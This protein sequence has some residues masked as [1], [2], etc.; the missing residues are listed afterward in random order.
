VRESERQLRLLFETM[1]QGVVYQDSQGRITSLNPAAE[2]I[3]GQTAAVLVGRDSFGSDPRTKREDDTLFPPGEQPSAVAFNSGTAVHAVTMGIYNPRKHQYRWVEVSAVPLIREG[4]ARPYQVYT[5]LNDVTE[6]KQAAEALRES[7]ARLRLAVE[8]T[9]VGTFDFYPKTGALLW[10]DITKSHFGLSPQAAIDHEIFLSAVHPDDRERIRRKGLEVTSPGSDGNL[11]TEYRTIGVED[12]KER[13]LSVRGRVLYDSEGR[14]ERLIGTTLDI[15]ER[16]SLEEQ[17]RRRAEECQKIM[18]VAPVVLHVAHDRDCEMVTGNRAGYDLHET[19]EGSNLSANPGLAAVGTRF[20]RNG[21]ELRPEQLPLQIAAARGEEV[22]D[23]EVELLLPSGKKVV[24]WGHATPLRDATGQVRGAVGAFQ[25][26][27]RSKRRNEAALRESE[28]RFR[29]MADAAPIVMW[30]GDGQKRVTFFNKEISAF[31]GLPREQLLGVG[32]AQIIHPDDLEAAR[33]GYYDAVDRRTSNQ[34]EYRAR[35]A[36]GEYR[37]MLGTTS[38]RYIEDEY[39]GQVGTVIDITELK[40]RQER[41]LARQKLE[42]LG[43]LA[44]GIAHDFNNL[45]GGVLSQVEL[46]LSEMADGGSP[47]SEIKSIRAVALRGAE[48]VRQLMVYAGQETESL[49]LVDVSRLVEETVE[50][51]RVVISKHAL[52]DLRLGSPTPAVE[53][54]PAR[55]RQLVMNLVTNASEAIGN[56]DGV[57]RISTE[58][59]TAGGHSTAAEGLPDGDYLQLEVSDT[60]C[61]MSPEAQSKVFDPFFTTKAKGR[62]LGLAVVQGIVRDLGGSIQVHSVRGQG[63]TFRVLL[64]GSWSIPAP[65]KLSA[66]TGVKECPGGSVLLVEDEETLRYAISKMLEGRGFSVLEAADG[67]EAIRILRSHA[68]EL[69]VMLLDVTLPGIGSPEVMREAK[70]IRP[71]LRVILTSAYSERTVA[72]MFADLTAEAFVRKP[73]QVGEIV[74]LIR[75]P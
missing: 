2:R 62:G 31:S 29:D 50:L 40:R 36:D 67:S 26:I 66:A 37:N 64:P 70:R 21:V 41:D 46:A 59:L 24:M 27:T 16:K 23:S 4:E 63:A 65:G 45:L 22:R 7:E 17:L 71:H 49:E 39:A 28:D 11:A 30:L 60:G 44:G 73:Y 14:A 5:I 10:S 18:E 74:Q 43:T 1:Q 9:Q 47:E 54:N 69:E 56:R 51:L 48:I 25:D 6:K 3:L 33:A 58:H 20:F 72:G 34:L 55:L 35:R 32:W 38:P 57:I 19:V 52:L 75:R 68:G 8:A 42:S 12:G 13:W 15:T 53:S 61:G